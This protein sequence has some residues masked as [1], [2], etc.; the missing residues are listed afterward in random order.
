M[1][2]YMQLTQ[3]YLSLPCTCHC[4]SQIRALEECVGFGYN[5]NFRYIAAHTIAAEL[6]ARDCYSCLSS[7]TVILS[8]LSVV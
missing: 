6:G 7:R 1:V 3:M 5:K 4:Y 8:H 2:L